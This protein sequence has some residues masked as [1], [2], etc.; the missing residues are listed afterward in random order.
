VSGDVQIDGSQSDKAAVTVES[1]SGNIR[2]IL[3]AN[4]SASLVMKTFSG[5][6]SLRR[7]RH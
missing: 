3:P 4:P 7:S 2:L 6:V 5:D 1:L